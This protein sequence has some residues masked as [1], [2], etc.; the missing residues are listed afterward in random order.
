MGAELHPQLRSIPV[1]HALCTQVGLHRHSG[2]QSSF[3]IDIS[4]L[5]TEVQLIC[6]DFILHFYAYRTEIFGLFPPWN[7]FSSAMSIIFQLWFWK[8]VGT[9]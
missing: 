6:L 8:Q 2:I 3:G 5:L 1:H 7:Y 4:C 9:G